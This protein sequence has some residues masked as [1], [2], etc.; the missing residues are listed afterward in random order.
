MGGFL[1]RAFV[2]A[3]S[4]DDLRQLHELSI[5]AAN[6]FD[7]SQD[8]TSGMVIIDPISSNELEWLLEILLKP[9]GDLRNGLKEVPQLLLD[10]VLPSA[11]RPGC[12]TAIFA[13]VD[14]FRNSLLQGL[15]PAVLIIDNAECIPDYMVFAVCGAFASTLNRVALFAHEDGLASLVTTGER[16]HLR[17]QLGKTTVSRLTK[18]G[19]KPMRL[20]T[21][22]HT[23]PDISAFFRSHA[24][25]A[26]VNTSR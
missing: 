13:T 12:A 6:D 19:I 1:G 15:R 16:N 18:I 2:F 4:R 11:G 24:Y 3:S 25:N 20:D 21:Q 10:N 9:W 22:Y 26:A 14:S 5:S 23:D 7:A 8:L 17:S